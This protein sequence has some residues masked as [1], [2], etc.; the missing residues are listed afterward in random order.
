[1]RVVIIE[2]PY[3][4]DVELNTRYAR[5]CVRDCLLRGEAPYASH[6]LYTQDGILDDTIPVERAA[7][8]EAGLAFSHVAEC[9]YVYED[10]GISDG[11]RVGIERH[12]SNGTPVEYRKL[13]AEAMKSRVLAA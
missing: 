6:L 11:M 10:L 5:A 7:G 2:S 3:A 13:P 4:D 8:I 1:M 9:V 12:L